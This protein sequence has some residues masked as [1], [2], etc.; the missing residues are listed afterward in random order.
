RREGPQ[1]EVE[2]TGPF[3]LGVHPVTQE[4]YERVTGSN[5]SWFA[6]TGQG[7]SEVEKIDTKR[8]PVESVSWDDAV[9]FCERLSELPE[10]VA[11]GRSYR[12]PTEAEWE[13]ACRGG[14]L[15]QH[16]SAPFY[17]TLPTF[18]L[19]ATLANFDGNY[20][21]GSDKK[22]PYL[23][24]PTPVGSYLANPLGLHD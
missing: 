18:A 8:F 21:Y 24:R 19:D 7:A 16:L 22:G 10:E 3:L 9:A 17:F 5:P 20:P 11:A 15:F 6:A 1:H 23:R 2:I 14:R 13:Y 4:E 12:L